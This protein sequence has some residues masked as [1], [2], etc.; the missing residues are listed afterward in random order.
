MGARATGIN[1]QPKNRQYR[2]TKSNSRS[3][4]VVDPRAVVRA[5]DS[6]ALS[7]TGFQNPRAVGNAINSFASGTVEAAQPGFNA[8]NT[9]LAQPVMPSFPLSFPRGHD[10]VH[11][12]TVGLGGDHSDEVSGSPCTDCYAGSTSFHQVDH[13]LSSQAPLPSFD[14]Y[15]DQSMH[16]QAQR[17]ADHHL[18]GL[19]TGRMMGENGMMLRYRQ[20]TDQG[21][22]L[23]RSTPSQ[24]DKGKR[25]FV[26]QNPGI[27]TGL[28]SLCPDV[29]TAPAHAMADR[30][31]AGCVELSEGFTERFSPSSLEENTS[32][33][34]L[35][36]THDLM[37]SLSFDCDCGKDCECLACPE[38][39]DNVTTR[40]TTAALGRIMDADGQ[41]DPEN[42]QG[43][44]NN[45]SYDT[46]CYSR[47]SGGLP[48]PTSNTMAD[49]TSPGIRDNTL[50]TFPPWLE[51][52]QPVGMDML[53]EYFTYEIP[54]A[55]S[56][57][58]CGDGCLCPNCPIHSGH[59]SGS[60][61]PQNLA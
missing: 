49:N 1:Q 10:P 60:S 25:V 56:D 6:G 32:S 55:A 43:M 20:C 4:S 45:N 59:A 31:S 34:F 61:S 9:Q 26:L 21:T 50:Q 37:A 41:Q 51:Q 15:M 46:L 57:C 30:Q 38:H 48:F 5:F 42:F 47:P 35:P 40:D 19:S 13:L 28:S 11:P 7:A 18:G 3:A 8:Q 14:E 58:T 53:N 36:G 12:P 16:L 54:V 22:C 27:N 44:L 23:M 2:V 29:F 39:P 17:R 52:T 24:H 33:R